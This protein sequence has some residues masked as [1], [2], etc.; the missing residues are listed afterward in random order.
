[1]R[2]VR[3]PFVPP[4]VESIYF[5]NFA[6]FGRDAQRRLLTPE[7]RARRRVGPG[8]SA[9]ARGVGRYVLN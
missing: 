2:H 7:V 5:D 1:V 9:G 8:R 3:G 6:V 4:D